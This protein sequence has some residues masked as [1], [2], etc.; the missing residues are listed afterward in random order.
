MNIQ[1]R[2]NASRHKQVHPQETEKQNVTL[3]RDWYCKLTSWSYYY[4]KPNGQQITNVPL[5]SPTAPPRLTFNTPVHGFS[6][7]GWCTITGMP[8]NI[9]GY[10]ALIKTETKTGK[11][12]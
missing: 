11:R 1:S 7:C 4:H 8:T 12:L 9:Y 5:A 3:F 2:E 6:K 10:V